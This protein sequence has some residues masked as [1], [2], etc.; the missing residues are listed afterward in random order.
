ME[1]DE[2]R[3]H[4]EAQSGEQAPPRPTGQPAMVATG[5]LQ[6]NPLSL[7]IYGDEAVDLELAASIAQHGVLEPLSVLEDGTIVS[8]H[9][10]WRAAQAAGLASVP[11]TVVSFDDPLDEHTALIEH[12]RQRVKSYSQRMREADQLET[13]ERE[14]AEQRRR[15]HGGTAPGR[16]A[17][18]AG[19]IA[20]SEAGET[21][22]KVAAAVGMKARSFA[23]VRSVYKAAQ[24]GSEVAAKQLSALDAG[25][26]TINAAYQDVRR[27]EAGRCTTGL[28]IPTQHP[29]RRSRLPASSVTSGYLASIDLLAAMPPTQRW[30]TV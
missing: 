25:E 20:G 8:G 28:V 14:R 22:D 12:N 19:N 1:T 30:W 21:R 18:T 24:Q 17:D 16:S 9:R 2:R 23:K 5:S 29:K 27:E 15:H 13:I 3:P 10:R 7:A 4:H 6:P 11:A 26:I